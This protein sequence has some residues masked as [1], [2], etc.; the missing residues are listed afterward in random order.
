MRK[1]AGLSALS[2]HTASSSSY[3]SLS[4]TITSTQLTTLQSSLT[5]FRDTLLQ[6]A[7]SHA[8]D[9]RRDPAFRH[10]FQKM[11]AAIGIDP[12]ASTSTASRT[13]SWNLLLGLGEWEYELAVQVVDVCVSTRDRNGGII[14]MG[15]LL[16]RLE[17]MR[18]GGAVTRED[19]VQVSE[20]LK[21]LAGYRVVESGGASFVRS[22]PRELDVDQSALLALAATR[23][24]RLSEGV[25]K[26]S[27]GWSDVRVRSALE[28]CV[29][30]EGVGWVDEQVGGASRE[31]WIIA[32]VDLGEAG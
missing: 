30:R 10:Q 2:R 13:S 17:K 8:S 23:G 29:M 15:D 7:T 27:T 32:A 3:A 5:S 19:V 20:L 28:D 11:C 25:L 18:L 24:G 4:S 31:V 6:F 1:G 12:L 16:K 9:I 21:P 22:V 26:A 14:E